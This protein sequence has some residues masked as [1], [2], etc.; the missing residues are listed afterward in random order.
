[1]TTPHLIAVDTSAAPEPWWY[2]Y[3]DNM[4]SLMKAAV[5]RQRYG[6]VG[7]TLSALSALRARNKDF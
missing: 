6:G 2:P 7:A 4:L 5:A 3:T 1:M